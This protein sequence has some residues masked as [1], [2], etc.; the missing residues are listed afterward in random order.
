MDGDRH[1]EQAGRSAMKIERIITATDFSAAGN[2]A[3]AT[4]ALW[5]QQFGAA[6]RIV[7][8]TP[9]AHWLGGLWH[10]QSSVVDSIQQN[11]AKALRDVAERVDPGRQLE[12]S[13]GVLEGSAT[14]SIL[15]AAD[16]F[17]ADL[18][19]VGARGEREIAPSQS[20]LG[21]TSAKLVDAVNKPLMLARRDAAGVPARVLAAVDLLPGS[22]TVLEWAE[23]FTRGG[24]LHA[25]HAYE[26]PFGTRLE[27][28][29]F[30]RA[31]VDV[32][33]Q[34]EHSK[35]EQ[36]LETLLK[37]TAGSAGFEFEVERGE[38]VELLNRY[39]KIIDANLLVM[40]KHA[41][42]SRHASLSTPGSV[43]RSMAFDAPID[44]L[45]VPEAMRS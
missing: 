11:A 25:F 27:A 43:C 31:A 16:E 21:G 38:P 41:H 37:A 44:L 12:L 7:H 23:F 45:I 42:R 24:S 40:G 34:Q 28:Y 13:T 3:A 10:A 30:S 19:V 26:M 15:H 20:G 9:P 5:A 4:A 6:L 1:S 35:R 8:V 33:S 32:Y 2:R 39:I 29:G 14:K 18:L 36:E 22:D 17:H